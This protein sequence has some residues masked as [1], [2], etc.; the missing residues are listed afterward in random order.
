MIILPIFDVAHINFAKHLNILGCVYYLF[1]IS[2]S[3]PA[4]I[5][6]RRLDEFNVSLKK[7][8]VAC[9]IDCTDVMVNFWKSIPCEHQLCFAHCIHLAVC[10]VLYGKNTTVISATA[11]EEMRD[12][13]DSPY[14]SQNEELENEDFST[15]IDLENDCCKLLSTHPSKPFPR[16]FPDPS[17]FEATKLRHYSSKPQLYDRCVL[18]MSQVAG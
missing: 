11:S 6:E 2:S 5:V 17:L 9:V 8:V 18:V 10:D 16:Q 1:K 15:A 4:E 13:D 12:E 14:L 7:H 3:F